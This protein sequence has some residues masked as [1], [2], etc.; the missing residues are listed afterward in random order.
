MSKNL[1]LIVA[2]SRGF[3]DYGLLRAKL[4]ALLATSPDAVIVSGGASGA[5]ALGERYA[6]DRGLAV[7]RFPAQWQAYGRAAGPIR[8]Q[9]MAKYADALVAFWDGKSRGTA[10]MIWAARA[11]G[12]Q[13]RV[14]RYCT[15]C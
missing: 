15:K 4:D 3:D 2:G 12:L 5:D 13:V 8:N 14:I 1:K 11:A 6:K 7:K 10:N 9:A